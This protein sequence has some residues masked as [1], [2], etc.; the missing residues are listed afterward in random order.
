[1]LPDGERAEPSPPGRRATRPASAAHP[2]A[3][4]PPGREPGGFRR[5][6]ERERLQIGILKLVTGTFVGPDGFTFERE[7]VRHQGAV[8]IVPVED[9]GH[10]VVCVR[11]YRAPVDR[12]VLELPAGK[13]D[14]PGEP[15]AATAARELIEETG[16]RATSLLEICS[17]LNSPGFS[18]EETICYLAEGLEAVER[19]AQGVEERHMSVGRLD[20]DQ[21]FDLVA[22]GEVVDA[23]TIVACAVVRNLLE[24]RRRDA[25]RDTDDA[26]ASDTL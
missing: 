23:K 26:A 18:D 7:I 5:I 9:D 16:F 24:E 12:F 4:V 25:A 6:G 20:L 21:L 1:M 8:C 13:R 19:E 10:Q 11:Q 15:A 3:L 22:T 2:Q 17:F 14:V